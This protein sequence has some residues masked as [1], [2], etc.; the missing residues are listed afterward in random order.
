MSA[1]YWTHDPTP[2]ELLP[3]GSRIRDTNHPELTGRIKG[4][5]YQRPHVLSAIP[6]LIEWDDSSLAHRLRGFLFVYSSGRDI[7]AVA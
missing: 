6:Y 1:A 7:E 4:W 3:I 5:E 2:A